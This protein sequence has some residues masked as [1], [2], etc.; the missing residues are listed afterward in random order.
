MKH[1]IVNWKH[2]KCKGFYGDDVN[3]P[4]AFVL[5]ARYRG[6]L[7]SSILSM[8]PKRPLSFDDAMR[9]LSDKQSEAF[10]AGQYGDEPGHYGWYMLHFV[11]WIS[12]LGYHIEITGEEFEAQSM[13]DKLA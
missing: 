9:M 11:E 10:K 1:Q 6:T 7:L 3:L 8:P 13:T 12:S 4:I 5:E 2:V